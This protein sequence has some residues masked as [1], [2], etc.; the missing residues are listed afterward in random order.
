MASTQGA[1]AAGE[2]GGA[3]AAAGRFFVTVTLY[4]RVYAVSI[5]I[6]LFGTS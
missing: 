4:I 5:L 6:V 3:S 1:A 2:H